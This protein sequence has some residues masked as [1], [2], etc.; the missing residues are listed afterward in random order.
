MDEK[1]RIN[2]YDKG[3]AE[4]RDDDYQTE[5]AN[6]MTEA[7]LDTVNEDSE[8]DPDISSVYGWIDIALSVIAFF[9]A[10]ILFEAAGIIVGFVSRVIG[11]RGLGSNALGIG[12]VAPIVGFLLVPMFCFREKSND[13]KH[14]ELFFFP[15]AL[16]CL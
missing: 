3:I 2:R 8:H 9:V 7:D 10:P 6:E 11:A 5:A 14:R 4:E 13:G 1:N 16:C 15:S 12:I